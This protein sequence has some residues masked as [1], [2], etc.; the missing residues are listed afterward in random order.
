MNKKKYIANILNVDESNI[1]NDTLKYYYTKF[2]EWCCDYD[3]KIMF[4][5]IGDYEFTKPIK[6]L[7]QYYDSDETKYFGNLY[8]KIKKYENIKKYINS[9]KED[10]DIDQMML[11]Y[12][13]CKNKMNI[14]SL[15]SKNDKKDIIKLLNDNGKI[16]YIKTIKMNYNGLINLMYFLN[17]QNK[18][19]KKVDDIK[20]FLSQCN[21]KE[22][23][24]NSFDI[25]LY[26]SSKKIPIEKYKYHI[27]EHF[28]QTVEEAQIYFC[29]NSRD[30]MERQILERF[31]SYDMRRCR[32]LIN[33]LKK[34]IV[35]NIDPIDRMRFLLLSGAILYSY[36][37]RPCGDVDAFIQH[38]PEK[39]ITKNFQK[40]IEEN[41]LDENTKFWFVDFYTKPYKTWK[42]FWNK[43]HVEW[44]KL[45][46]AK[47]IVDAT[48]N[49]K[50]HFYYMGL[51]FLILDG[52]IV[53]RLERGR[54]RA[55]ADIIGI[56]TVLKTNIKIPNIPDEYWVMGEIHKIDTIDKLNKFI[57]SIIIALKKRFRIYMNEDEIK[58]LIP[59]YKEMY[60]KLTNK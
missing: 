45:F 58:K 16:Y 23:V 55:F 7:S 5:N 32:I 18:D 56:N 20:N 28:Y 36:G 44:A 60:N 48:Y 21:F 9:S 17:A 24:E 4:D 42:D 10:E 53:R 27:T 41:L 25:I 26:E 35:D 19:L 11:Q 37:I 14:M 29:K 40:I 12:T 51:K 59:N 43:W 39:A 47:S 46:G 52:D 6:L 13:K 57:F 1:K 33:T 15:W 49:P 3:E 54:P 30:F 50:F 8:K 22:N 31:I 38:K 34:W 2:P